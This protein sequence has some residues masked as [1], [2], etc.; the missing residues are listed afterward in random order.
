MLEKMP[1]ILQTVAP[2]FNDFD[3]VIKS[4]D[5]PTRQSV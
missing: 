2:A 4:L 1:N 5:K 3:L